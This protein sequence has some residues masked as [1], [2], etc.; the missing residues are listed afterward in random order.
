MYVLSIHVKRCYLENLLRNAISH[1]LLED[2]SLALER[3]LT[4]GAGSGVLSLFE[5]RLL[6]EGALW[7]SLL[8]STWSFWDPFVEPFWCR[9]S[10]LVNPFGIAVANRLPTEGV[11]PARVFFDA[12]SGER[13]GGVWLCFRFLWYLLK[14]L[15]NYTLKPKGL[16]LPYRCKCFITYNTSH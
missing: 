12:G 4:G 1:F 13:R 2:L 14:C 7:V 15:A 9:E 8:S 6:E 16:D 10:P 5:L 3:V 11:S